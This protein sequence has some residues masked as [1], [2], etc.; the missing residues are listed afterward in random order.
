MTL[1]PRGVKVHL[2]FGFIDMR[3]GIDG[4]SQLTSATKSAPNRLG[5]RVFEI[6]AVWRQMKA[7]PIGLGRDILRLLYQR[8]SRLLRKN[9]PP[10]CCLPLR[11]S[12]V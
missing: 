2:A 11:E 1:L 7:R 10:A 6:S 5:D 8:T 9:G 12:D 4:L 3:K